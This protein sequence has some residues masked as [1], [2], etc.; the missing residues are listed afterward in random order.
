MV[1]INNNTK[2][3]ICF[4]KSMIGD[5]RTMALFCFIQHGWCDTKW[6]RWGWSGSVLLPLCLCVALAGLLILAVCPLE[7]VW[8][9]QPR[10]NSQTLVPHVEHGTD[11]L[12]E[13]DVECVQVLWAGAIVEGQGASI[14]V[15]QH[16]HTTQVGGRFDGHLLAVVTYYPGVVAA[17]QY[18]R[19]RVLAD[20]LMFR[21]WLVS[22]AHSKPDKDRKM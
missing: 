14:V 6:A 4:Y 16:P 13:G 18:P 9:G 22:N 5:W 7:V 3:C 10:E 1:S 20:P 12:S 8:D 2:K 15:Q 17:R 11:W 21:C 19:G